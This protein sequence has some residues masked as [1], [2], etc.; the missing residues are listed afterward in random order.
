MSYTRL[1]Y[2]L[3]NY[4]QCNHTCPVCNKD[5]TRNDIT[6]NNFVFSETKRKSKMLGHRICIEK[7]LLP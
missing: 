7:E 5:V 6:N 4:S 1:K 2:I 3:K